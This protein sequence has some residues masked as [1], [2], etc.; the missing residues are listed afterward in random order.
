[1]ERAIIKT[2]GFFPLDIV[3]SKV[4]LEHLASAVR[5]A[6]IA[7]HETTSGKCYA[8]EYGLGYSCIPRLRRSSRMFFD[9]GVRRAGGRRFQ[10]RRGPAG[11]RGGGSVAGPAEFQ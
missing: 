11:G 1:M 3:Y 7:H 10:D 8:T 5:A 2:N 6:P 4:R 9:G